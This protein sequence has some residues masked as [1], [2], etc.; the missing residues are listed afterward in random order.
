MYPAMYYVNAL[1][2]VVL[3]LFLTIVGLVFLLELVDEV[4]HK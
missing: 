4:L 1:L 3:S 2:K